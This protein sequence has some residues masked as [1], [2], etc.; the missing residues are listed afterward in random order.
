MTKKALPLIELITL[1]KSYGG[2][3]DEPAVEILHG[4]DLT[5]RAGEFVALVGASGSGKSTL[6]HLLGCLDRPTS[7]T[8]RFAGR[9]VSALSDDELAWLRRE[10][11]GFVFQGYHL[12]RTLDALHNVQVPAVYAGV[13]PEERAERASILLERLGLAERY[14]HRPHQLSGGQQQRVSIARALMNGGQVILADEP[15]GALD[16]RYSRHLHRAR[17]N[18]REDRGTDGEDR[19]SRPI[20]R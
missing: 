17:K 18:G 9:D 4:I 1:R 6:M 3:D 13:P 2:R 10:A 5:I 12:I 8:Y 19:H 14:G 15:T 20:E 11:F 7:G 16:N